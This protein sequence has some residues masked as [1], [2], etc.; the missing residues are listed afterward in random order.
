MRFA[1]QSYPVPGIGAIRYAVVHRPVIPFRVIGPSG[2]VEL[3]ALVDTGA[4]DTLVREYLVGPLGVAIHPADQVAI[5]GMGGALTIVRFATVELELSRSGRTY[6]WSTR[7][8]F[9]PGLKP[10]LGHLGFLEHFTATFNGR[11]RQLT[12]QPGSSTLTPTR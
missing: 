12:L 3:M 11:Q 1:Y 10:I 7:I 8:G 9:Y 5:T 4:D 2:P 6:R